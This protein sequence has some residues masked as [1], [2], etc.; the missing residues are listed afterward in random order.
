MIYSRNALIPFSDPLTSFRN[1][2]I[3]QDIH[4]FPK[5]SSRNASSSLDHLAI[6][7]RNTL[8]SSKNPW[9]CMLLRDQQIAWWNPWLSLRHPWLSQRIPYDFELLVSLKTVGFPEDVFVLLEESTDFFQEA[10][11]FLAEAIGLLENE[12]MDFLEASKDCL[13]V[14]NALL[15]LRNTLLPS[16][17]PFTSWRNPWTSLR[18]T[19]CNFLEKYIGSL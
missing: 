19:Y 8:A 9:H 5:L 10:I 11:D 7:C 4:R 13:E 15:Q 18:T 1:L 3:P 6:S 12:S 14:R 2:S 17:N 16:V